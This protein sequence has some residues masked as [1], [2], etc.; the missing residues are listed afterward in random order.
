MKQSPPEAGA[1][2]RRRCSC[3]R[4]CSLTLGR[5]TAVKYSNRSSR[6]HTV[7]VVRNRLTSHDVSSGPCR[8]EFASRR[9]SRS[10]ASPPSVAESLSTGSRAPLAAARVTGYAGPRLAPSTSGPVTVGG[11]GYPAPLPSRQRSILRACSSILP[12]SSG[13]E[14]PELRPA[15]IR[16]S[17]NVR[18][19]VSPRRGP[20]TD[21]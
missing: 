17:G 2:V 18:T 1:P 13:P 21:S 20:A 4:S 10:R 12:I 6:S 8:R 16:R 19:V 9:S 15:R 5:R 11:T 14:E 3:Q 7:A